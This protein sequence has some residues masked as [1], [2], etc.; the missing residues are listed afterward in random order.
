[1]LT[2]SQTVAI[3]AAIRGM[4][5]AGKSELAWQYQKQHRDFYPGGVWWLPTQSNQSLVVQVLAY[6]QRL[7]GR[8]WP[9]IQ[10]EQQL[11]QWCYDQWQQ[12]FAGRKLLILDNVEDYKTL[13]PYLPQQAEFRILITTQ[14]EILSSD[15]RLDLGGLPPEKAEELLA[16]VSESEQRLV[17]EPDAVTELCKWLGYL[18]L[19]IELVG[20]YLADTSYSVGEVLAMPKARSIQAPPLQDVPDDISYQRNIQAAFELAWEPLQPAAQTVA[21]FLSLFALAPISTEL[22]TA[23]LPEWDVTEVRNI[24]D[25]VLFKRSLLSKVADSYLLHSLMRE[26]LKLKFA[27]LAVGEELKTSFAIGLTEIAK[28]IPQI[29][30]IEKQA[31]VKT[32]IPHLEQVI[33]LA[34]YLPDGDDK[35][36]CCTGLAR[37]YESRSLYGKAERVLKKALVI[38]EEELGANHLSTANSLN[39]LAELYL[40][41]GKYPVAKPLFVRALTIREQQLGP[42]HPDTAVSLNNLAE[43][44]K[45]MGRYPEAEPLCLRS[46]AIKEQQL[47]ANHPDTATSLNNLATL[48]LTMGRYTEAELLF[49]RSLAISEEQ[50]GVNHPSTATSLNNLATLYLTMGRYTEAEPL[51]VRVLAIREEQLGANHPDTASS[52]NNLAGLY[53]SMGRYPAAEPLLVR[54]LVTTEEQLGANHPDTA[55]SLDNLAELYRSMGR[56][57]AARPLYLRSLAIREEQLGANHPDT[58]TSLNNLALLYYSM[59][60]YPVAEL[61]FVKAV[62]ILFNQL[63][64]GHPN[65]QTFIKNFMTFLQQLIAENQTHLLSNHPVTQYFL[66]QLNVSPP[67]NNIQTID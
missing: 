32:S 10:D 40:I 34:Q 48:Y 65:T 7:Q 63:G 25:R 9:D 26:F 44:Y 17:A 4:S 46:L 22:I 23:G 8:A 56:Y 16:K 19:G 14:K 52:L 64:E 66:Q 43:L 3:T 47:G 41:M 37:F 54:A 51:L 27:E 18:P 58:A 55:T 24:L 62:G 29:V 35:I 49:V 38:S 21:A 30:T 12:S 6:L 61:L 39:N 67:E 42:N 33:D 1:M 57:P 15:K 59:S 13:K 11:V 53:Y 45:S 28:T 31:H 36:W 5:G 60:K 50:L 2:V 20:K